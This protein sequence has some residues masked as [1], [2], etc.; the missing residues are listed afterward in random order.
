MQV[1]RKCYSFERSD[2]LIR[3]N[4]SCCTLWIKAGGDWDMLKWICYTGLNLRNP[5]SPNFPLFN[6]WKSNE[7][8][9]FG[10]Q[11]WRCGLFFKIEPV[12]PSNFDCRSKVIVTFKTDLLRISRIIIWIL[13]VRRGNVERNDGRNHISKARKR[14][15]WFSASMNPRRAENQSKILLFSV[16]L[17]TRR[18]IC[19]GW[20]E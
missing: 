14:H 4:N 12:N 13:L 5:C 3:V 18:T 19:R 7:T 8:N 16:R 6:W 1:W 17:V 9:S 15:S 20:T 10:T 11:L 2:K